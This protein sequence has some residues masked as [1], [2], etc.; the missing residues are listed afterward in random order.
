[1]GMA[2][3]QPTR[4]WALGYRT[5]NHMLHFC[6]TYKQPSHMPSC[7]VEHSSPTTHLIVPS[8]RL[9]VGSNG[10]NSVCVSGGDGVD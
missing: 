6:Y 1:M 3:A 8:V 10:M 4:S 2:A 5:Q 9:T 7:T